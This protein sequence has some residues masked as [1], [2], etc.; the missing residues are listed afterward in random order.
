[1][2][3]ASE[4]AAL[5]DTAPPVRL[6]SCTLQPVDVRDDDAQG[7]GP[8]ALELAVGD[9]GISRELDPAVAHGAGL[10]LCSRVG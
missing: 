2:S 3:A 5:A 7:P 9:P 8:S 6:G 4:L 10:R 1:M